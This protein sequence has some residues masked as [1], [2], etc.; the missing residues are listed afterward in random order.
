MKKQIYMYIYIFNRGFLPN[1]RE[2]RCG[3]NWRCTDRGALSLL[4]RK[5]VVAMACVDDTTYS[6]HVGG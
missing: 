3:P 2:I 6:R 5:I 4:P 1:T